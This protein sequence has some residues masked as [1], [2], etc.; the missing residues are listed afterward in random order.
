MMSKLNSKTSSKQ[1]ISTFTHLV[2]TKTLLFLLIFACSNYLCVAFREPI[3]VYKYLDRCPEGRTGPSCDLP[4]EICPDDKRLCFFNGR[5]N[6]LPETKNGYLYECNCPRTS[7]ESFSGDECQHPSTD[8][9]RSHDSGLGTFCV[10]GGSCSRFLDRFGFEQFG[11]LCPEEFVGEHCQYRSSSNGIGGEE[12]FQDRGDLANMKYLGSDTEPNPNGMLLGI[13]LGVFLSIGCVIIVI[14]CYYRSQSFYA[15]KPDDSK[16][17]MINDVESDARS[18][19]SQIISEAAYN[20]PPTNNI[21]NILSVSNSSN[22]KS[23]SIQNSNYSVQ[24]VEDDMNYNNTRRVN[25]S[26]AEPE[27]GTKTSDND[28]RIDQGQFIEQNSDENQ[29][30]D[31]KKNLPDII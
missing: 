6:R 16:T 24:E 26:M 18:D 4:Y 21:D 29:Q 22:P 5:C 28:I 12:I 25:D 11:C 23:E 10:N 9:C 31:E 17:P 19:N 20:G 8:L 13:F 7:V 3:D 2:P 1:V 14:L 15:V 27:Q 30:N